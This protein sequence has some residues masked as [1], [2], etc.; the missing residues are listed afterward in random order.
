MPIHHAAEQHSTPVQPKQKRSFLKRPKGLHTKKRTF[1]AFAVCVVVIAGLAG[2]AGYL[3]HQNQQL[4]KNTSNPN[5]NGQ[6]IADSITQKVAKL[7][8]IPKG[9]TP[10][11]ATIKDIK[12]LQGQAFFNNAQN[13]DSVL[14]FTKAKLAIVYREKENKIINIGPV[15]T[16]PPQ[17]QN[18]TNTPSTTQNST[19]PKR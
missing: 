7:Y 8:A 4:K 9:E 2:W 14:I 5:A 18:G 16:T 1:L 13:G 11:V 15:D 17:Q 6:A 3:Y 12:Q 10:T 19:A